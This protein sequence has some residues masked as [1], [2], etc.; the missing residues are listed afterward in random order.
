MHYFYYDESRL[1]KELRILPYIEILL[2][3]LFMLVG[4][5]RLQL[6]KQSEQANIWGRTLP[7]NGASTPARRCPDARLAR[8]PPHTEHRVPDSVRRSTKWRT[9]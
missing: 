1:V 2:G 4:L 7:R 9:T 3:G 5:H 6:Y 8:A